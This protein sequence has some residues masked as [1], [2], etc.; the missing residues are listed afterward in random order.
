MVSHQ[1]NY[2]RDLCTRGVWLDNGRIRLDGSIDE[3][4]LAYGE[5]AGAGASAALSHRTDR[6]GSGIVKVS[7]IA[8]D[9]G[10]GKPLAH[11]A[12]GLPIGLTVHLDHPTITP[13]QRADIRLEIVDIYG[14]V[15]MVADNGISG[16]D[17][18]LHGEASAWRCLLPK[19]PLNAQVYSVNVRVRLG[20][21]LADQL[22]GAFTFEVE[23]GLFYPT[24]RLPETR[25]GL[26]VDYTWAAAQD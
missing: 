8:L 13:G 26:L 11:A 2:L 22:S 15:I 10:R 4:V 12:S 6:R 18:S 16:Q 7:R 14:Q 25:E 19:L 23:P 21:A 3:A 17:I 20:Q 1:M 5:S 24:G 9:D